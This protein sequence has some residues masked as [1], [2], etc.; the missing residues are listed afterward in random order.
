MCK[1]YEMQ[2]FSCGH[3]QVTVEDQVSSFCAFN[4]TVGIC[5]SEL[6]DFRVMDVHNTSP[7]S[8]CEVAAAVAAA[9][10]VEAAR[11]NASGNQVPGA[12]TGPAPRATFKEM[13][14]Q[15]MLRT[16]LERN[17]FKPKRAPATKRKRQLDSIAQRSLKEYVQRDNTHEASTFAWLLRY[18]AAL[19]EW[20]DR[21]AMVGELEP[22]FG[23]LLDEL[24]QNSLRPTLKA[25]KCEDAFADLM[26]WTKDY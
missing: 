5:A 20:L 18:L 25:M 22:W 15:D 11:N 1:Y 2:H 3:S 26:V 12:P 7:C 17:S 24:Y 9:E 13:A 14:A 19:P 6:G 10:A 23:E 16:R 21:R 4:F 8:T